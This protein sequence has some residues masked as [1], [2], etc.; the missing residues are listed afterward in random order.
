MTFKRNSTYQSCRIHPLS[1]VGDYDECAECKKIRIA[2]K[3][4]IDIRN[5]KKINNVIGVKT[6]H[7]EKHSKL[8]RYA[9]RMRN[10]KTPS[11]MKFESLL[12][13]MRVKFKSQ[14]IVVPNEKNHGGYILDFYVKHPYR[15]CFEID[16]EYHITR[17]EKDTYRDKWLW[18][19]RQ[20]RTIRLT[21]D[22]VTGLNENDLRSM[23]NEFKVYNSKK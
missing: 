21:N 5:N 16:G 1:M 14:K 17:L 13:N 19:N 18:D 2:A 6:P 22:E 3:K 7:A 4:R 11:E 12:K 8:N 20:I 15:I 23:L 9:R 10:T